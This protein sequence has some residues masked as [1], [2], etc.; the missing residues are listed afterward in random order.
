MVDGILAPVVDRDVGAELLGRLEPGVGH[1]DGD[2]VGRA[3]QPAPM[4][5]DSPIGP[6][7]T[8]ATVSPGWTRPLST[9]TS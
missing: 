9:P 8:T 7:P 3:E 4:I 1:V 6:A 2:D 5:A